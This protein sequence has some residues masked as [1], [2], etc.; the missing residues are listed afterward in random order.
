MT[1]FLTLKQNYFKYILFL[2][3][4]NTIFNKETG[5]TE[6]IESD[7]IIS[8][9]ETLIKTIYSIIIR[10]NDLDFSQQERKIKNY[11]EGRTLLVIDDYES[12]NNIDKEKIIRFINNLHID[13]FKVL[14]TTRSSTEIR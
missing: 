2:S 6:G 5:I 8:D 9:Y 3:A 14:I 11:N 7:R 12:F 10:D 1:S 13:F 4:K